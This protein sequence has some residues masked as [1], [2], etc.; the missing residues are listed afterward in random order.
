M[1]T[2]VSDVTH[3]SWVGS[4]QLVK[5]IL[6]WSIFLFYAP[7]AV[8]GRFY[9]W[10]NALLEPHPWRQSQTALTILQLYQGTATLWDYRSPLGGIL[11]NNVYEFPL[12]Q[13]VVSLVM[14]SGLTLEQSS[15]LVTLVSFLLTALFSYLI[16]K[17]IFNQELAR[18]FLLIYLVNPF[19]V[20]FSRVCLID[21]FALAATLASVYGLIEIRSGSK[22]QM[23]NWLFFA[24]GGIVAGLAKINIWF[25]ITTAMF[26]LI[27][28]EFA[29]KK[30][31]KDVLVGVFFV[32]IVQTAAIL[33]WNYYRVTKVGSPADTPWLVGELGQRLELWRWKKIL[34][35][36]VVRSF[37]YDWLIIPF[38]FGAFELFKKS[39]TILFIVFGV[40][41]AH[42]IVFFQ[43]QTFHDY[44]LIACMPY[45]FF[46]AAVGLQ[47]LSSK[48]NLFTKLVSLA[49]LA[50]I[51]FKSFQLKYYYSTLSHDYRP[52]LKNILKLKELT[53]PQ[54]FVYWDAK[55]GRFEIPTYS[56]RNVGLSDSSRFLE[57]KENRNN[58]FNPTVFRFDSKPNFNLIG[59]PS[60]IWVDGDPDFFVY[61]VKPIQSIVFTANEQL[62]VLSAP[63]TGKKVNSLKTLMDNCQ[64][65]HSS[66]VEI[67]TEVKEVTL[68]S[69]DKKFEIKLPTY[70]K[71]INIPSR[72][73][74][75]CRFRIRY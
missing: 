57:K 62:A 21:F 53:T 17:K 70:N 10:N 2:R 61:R 9:F 54:D 25:F 22:T 35:D 5:K 59:F 36:F 37:F 26:C 42:T 32:L 58:L 20:I 45:L 75:G 66:I 6:F 65:G 16:I 50:L 38:V 18:W 52:E 44:Y 71:F 64:S 73:R 39:K 68:A 43:V 24:C 49:L 13:W 14:H 30:I 55:Q 63:P 28:L 4:A 67:P 34:W 47:A 7:L 46:V 19:G 33:M 12:Y 15:R 3:W 8:W 48:N 27:S 40:F 72:G 23:K 69:V 74:F 41:V 11:W 60:M 31:R 51:I 1:D 56:Q 29:Q